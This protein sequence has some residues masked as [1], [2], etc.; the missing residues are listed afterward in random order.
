MLCAG[1]QQLGG[2]GSGGAAARSRLQALSAAGRARDAGRC[3]SSRSV[4][5][6]A[7]AAAWVPRVLARMSCDMRPPCSSVAA[8]SSRR[9]DPS[10][11]RKLTVMLR[12]PMSNGSSSAASISRNGNSSLRDAATGTFRANA[13]AG[14]SMISPPPNAAHAFSV[15]SALGDGSYS[16]EYGLTHA[17]VFSMGLVPVAPSAASM[18]TK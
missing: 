12:T 14:E 10:S 4:K 11:L 17:S 3:R 8:A 1:A 2:R 13:C 9:S 15:S 5:D 18:R 7:I 6:R 16:A